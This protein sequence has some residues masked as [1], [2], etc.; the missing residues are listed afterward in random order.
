MTSILAIFASWH[1]KRIILQQQIAQVTRGLRYEDLKVMDED[2]NGKVSKLEF[3]EFMLLS[4]NRVDK[5]YL[6]RLHKQFSILDLDNNGFLDMK[7]LKSKVDEPYRHHS[8]PKLKGFFDKGAH[9]K[10]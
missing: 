6:S 7:D 1:S 5:D 9:L 10:I 3:L 2:N 4:T 8:F